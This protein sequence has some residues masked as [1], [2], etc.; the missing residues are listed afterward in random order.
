MIVLGV[1]FRKDNR[2]Y[3]FVT[4]DVKIKK[5]DYVLAKLERG[6]Y[7]G[8]V[9]ERIEMAK[10][11][12][13]PQIERK[14]TKDDLIQDAKNAALERIAF[15][16]CAERIKSHE[17]E[18]KLIRAQCLFDKS[19]LIFYYTADG[20]VD[21]RELLKDLVKRFRMRIELRQIGVRNETQMIGG[22]GPCGR[23]LCCS[24][25]LNTF[26]PVSVK[27]AKEQYMSLN[28]EKISGLCGRLMCCLAY[29]FPL[30][31]TFKEGLPPC[32]ETV[33]IDNIEGKIVRYSLLRQ[34]AFIETPEGQ[35]VEVRLKDLNVTLKETEA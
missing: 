21:F 33:K 28:P 32:G 13:L 10:E 14:A 26:V 4:N 9:I 12:P 3:K 23:E 6:P 5:G 34:S 8:Q 25:F 11:L 27:M 7:L 18:M 22:I 19:K 16:F 1:K 24:L 2:I 20:R 17:L 31:Q 35:E 15:R 29:E 30:Y